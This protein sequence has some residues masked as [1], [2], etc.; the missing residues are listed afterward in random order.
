[1]LRRLFLML[2][3]WDEGWGGTLE[4]LRRPLG[5]GEARAVFFMIEPQPMSPGC[6]KRGLSGES[7]NN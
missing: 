4:R 7:V 2:G 1:M 3:G 5:A 6:G